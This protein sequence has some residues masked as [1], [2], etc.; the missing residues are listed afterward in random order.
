MKPDMLQMTHLGV[1]AMMVLAAALVARAADD[2][3]PAMTGL[4]EARVYA[5]GTGETLGYR[6]MK[7]KNYDAAKKYP[8]VLFLHGAGER[9]SDNVAQLKHGMAVF[10]SDEFQAKNPA[11]IIVPQV[12][13]NQKW[14][15]TDWSKLTNSLPEKP[16]R[17]MRLAMELVDAMQK[18]FSIDPDRLY[19]TGISMGGYGT[20][21]AISRWPGKFAAAVPIC[22]G[23]DEKQAAK[24]T[25]LPIW[26]FHGDKDPAVP[27]VRSRN[28]IAAIKAAGG[29]PKYTEY[30]GVGHN[31]WD[32]AYAD[33]ALY[34]W[35]FAQK[36]AGH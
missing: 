22:G 24:L 7:P 30:P 33:P 4:F 35:L 29:D 23:G 10:S 20:W 27:V 15:D 8:L 31:S 2:V 21:D 13:P 36:R 6:M 12:P 28:M 18:E 9:G 26:C 1:A 14:S 17:N 11:L 25:K 3:P 19:I 32:N 34:D 16:S 5:D